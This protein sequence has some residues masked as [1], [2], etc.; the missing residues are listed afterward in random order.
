MVTAFSPMLGESCTVPRW[1]V[2][3]C[4]CDDEAKRGELWE[5]HV[6]DPAQVALIIEYARIVCNISR[7]EAGE[8][9]DQFLARRAAIH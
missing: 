1:V 6:K 4:E 2:E 9:M 3:F 7:D 8:V 5:T